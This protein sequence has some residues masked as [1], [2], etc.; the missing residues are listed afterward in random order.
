M[1]SSSLPP[2]LARRQFVTGY[3]WFLLFICFFG[4]C[5]RCC[6]EVSRKRSQYH[7]LFP[8]VRDNS[9]NKHLNVFISEGRVGNTEQF[10]TQTSAYTLMDIH[11]Y[12][13]KN[14]FGMESRDLLKQLC[15]HLL[16][17][18]VISTNQRGCKYSVIY[19]SMKTNGR[20]NDAHAEL[21]RYCGF[22]GYVLTQVT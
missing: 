11:R 10:K 4:V 14:S 3:S 15:S 19:P 5:A 1:C 7:L 18:A 12:I 2:P 21:L 20:L 16:N 13:G 17:L 8:T 9:Q 22:G 6:F